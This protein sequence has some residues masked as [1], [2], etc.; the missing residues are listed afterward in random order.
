[1]E[2]YTY[3]CM[4]MIIFVCTNAWLSIMPVVVQTWENNPLTFLCMCIHTC[5][6]TYTN[7]HSCMCVGRYTPAYHDSTTSMVHI[8]DS[9][10]TKYGSAVSHLDSGI[11]LCTRTFAANASC[12]SFR[13]VQQHHPHVFTCD[14][15][16]YHVEVPLPLVLLHMLYPLCLLTVPLQMCCV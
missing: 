1:M 9:N 11:V 2:W 6:N 3:V 5:S 8:T 4:Y 15:L 10:H 7:A 16:K 13:F 14:V 12:A